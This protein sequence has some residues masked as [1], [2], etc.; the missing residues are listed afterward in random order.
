[1]KT[2]HLLNT[3]IKRF[4]TLFYNIK[5]S[6][7]I[8]PEV[9]IIT[10]YQMFRPDFF[11]QHLFNKFTGL[12]LTKHG[13]EFYDNEVVNICIFKKNLLFIHSRQKREVYTVLLQ[14]QSGMRGEGNNNRLSFRFSC[15]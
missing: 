8:S 6:F 9:V 3:E 12:N 4:S 11:N 14:Y 7:T 1:M 10:Y 2:L 13:I 5:I 15:T